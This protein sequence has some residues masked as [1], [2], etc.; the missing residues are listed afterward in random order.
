MRS[1]LSI[2]DREKSNLEYTTKLTNK[3]TELQMELQDKGRDCEKLQKEIEALKDQISEAKVSTAADYDQQIMKEKENKQT[4]LSKLSKIVEEKESR[5]AQLVLDFEE[6]ENKWNIEKRKLDAVLKDTNRQL[7]SM[8][9][10]KESVESDLQVATE[11]LKRGSENSS[12]W[13]NS[14]NGNKVDDGSRDVPAE[15]SNSD[16]NTW[17][18]NHNN[19]NKSAKFANQGTRNVVKGQGTSMSIEKQSNV[20]RSS[21]DKGHDMSSLVCASVEIA[22]PFKRGVVP[23][24]SEG[25]N[26]FSEK[27]MDK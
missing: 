9:K 20:A 27:W 18:L 13:K 21:V 6:K 1:C 10:L 8:K 22:Q 7:Q 23:K 26:S 24:S 19:N 5:I 2:L 25:V 3:I 4:E 14:S 15:D 16:S 12:P 11:T 17:D